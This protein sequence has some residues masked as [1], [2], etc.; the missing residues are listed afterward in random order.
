MD[1]WENGNRFKYKITNTLVD[2]LVDRWVKGM[3]DRPLDR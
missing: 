2:G 3:V 1:G